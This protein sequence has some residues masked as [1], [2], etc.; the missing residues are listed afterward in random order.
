[1]CVIKGAK[2]KEQEEKKL[3]W[4]NKFEEGIKEVSRYTHMSTAEN[5]MKNV[6]VQPEVSDQLV[7][8]DEDID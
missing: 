2:D 8:Q 3:E 4:N 1:M 7:V 6:Q 5:G